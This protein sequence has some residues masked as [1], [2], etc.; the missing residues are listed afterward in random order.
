LHASLGNLAEARRYLVRALDHQPAPPQQALLL[1]RKLAAL[2]PDTPPGFGPRIENR[3]ADMAVRLESYWTC[4][5]NSFD[6]PLETG[7][8]EGRSD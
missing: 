6:A 2:D 3:H 5:P 1:K 8:E 4:R 7:A